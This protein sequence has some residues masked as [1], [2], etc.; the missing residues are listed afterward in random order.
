MDDGELLCERGKIFRGRVE[1][2]EESLLAR[3]VGDRRKS[4]WWSGQGLH[5]GGA[6]R[7]EIGETHDDA[8]LRKEF[9]HGAKGRQA[10]RRAHDVRGGKKP[11]G[12]LAAR[13]ATGEALA[14]RGQRVGSAERHDR[15]LSRREGQE[16]RGAVLSDDGRRPDEAKIRIPRADHRLDPRRISPAQPIEERSIG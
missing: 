8:L 5:A 9:G 13:T 6:V 10:A 12:A 15:D 1:I 4:A 11:F 3:R 14:R 16:K 2:D 7:I